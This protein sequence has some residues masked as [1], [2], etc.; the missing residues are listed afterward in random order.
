MTMFTPIDKKSL[1]TEV[2]NRIRSSIFNGSLKPGQKLLEQELSERMNTSRGPIREAFILLEHE[3]LVIRE[4]NRSVVVVDLTETDVE[5]IHSIRLSLELLALH[6]LCANNVVVN[7]RPMAEAIAKLRSSIVDGSTLE[8]A[9]QHD[10]DFHEEMIRASGHSRLLKLWMSLR[11]QIGYLIFIK[12]IHSFFDF[13]RG[14]DQ[15]VE[16]IRLIDRKDYLNAEHLMRT[17]LTSVL[18]ALLESFVQKMNA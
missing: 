16:F 17:H 4:A 10:L 12:N 18:D 8:D 2:S 3:G 5:E 13:E 14:C 7:T 1:S 6:Y 9:V 15:H 11:P